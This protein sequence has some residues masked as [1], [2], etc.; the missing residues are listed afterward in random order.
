MPTDQD[1]LQ[2]WV[3]ALGVKEISFENGARRIRVFD[4][5]GDIVERKIWAH[6][7]SNIS[8]LVFTVSLDDYDKTIEGEVSL[9]FLGFPSL[10]AF[11][12]AEQP[13]SCNEAA[14]R[15]R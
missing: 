9:G 13:S 6:C 15:N 2:C 4:V 14:L 12:Y 10:I 1:I 7:L 8:A 11:S 5:G 3:T